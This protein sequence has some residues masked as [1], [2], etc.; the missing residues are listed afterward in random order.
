MSQASPELR[1]L[2]DAA[3]GALNAGDLDAFVALTNEDVEFTSMVLEAEGTTFPG[4]DGVRDWWTTIR[5]AFVDVH[6]EFLDVRGSAD[7]GVAHIRV[8]GTLRGIP[9]QQLMWEA[10]K[11]REGKV[12][13]WGIFRTEAEAIHAVG[14]SR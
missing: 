6:W 11:L 5:G 12:S 4:H 9:L 8:T 1:A 2:A 10:F 13:W 14:L 7:G 3:L